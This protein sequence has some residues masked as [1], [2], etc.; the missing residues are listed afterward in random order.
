MDAS[1]FAVRIGG[2]SLGLIP[3]FPMEIP[4]DLLPFLVAWENPREQYAVELLRAPLR[5][6]G[7]LVSSAGR[8]Q[9]Y[10]QE[11]GWLRVYPSYQDRFGRAA[12]CDLR[13]DGRHRLLLPAGFRQEYRK[14]RMMSYLLGLEWIYMRH[15]AGLLHS[16]AVMLEGK[17][18]LFS[19]PSGI[20]KSTQAKLW[21][22]RFGAEILNGDRCLIVS[23]EEGFWGYGSPACGSSGI[24]KPAGAPI[25]G[26]FLLGQAQ[27]NRVYVPPPAKAFAALYREMTVNPWDKVFLDR[28]LTL[29]QAV[30]QS[31][32]IFC[33]DCLPEVSA[34]DLARKALRL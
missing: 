15:G 13:E 26:I 22:R 17:T 34:A 16:S 18:V 12:A 23:K 21:Q 28:M 5:P 2:I 19:G 29:L 32:P 9:I 14:P 25:A 24:R 11:H 1:R 6:T 20:G 10:R 33:L 30:T 8:Q 7:E 27:E 4:A 3:Q 31:L